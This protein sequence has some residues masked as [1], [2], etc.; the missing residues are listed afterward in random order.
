MKN[1]C[2]ALVEVDKN[3]VEMSVSKAKNIADH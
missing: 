1:S 2:L 3:I